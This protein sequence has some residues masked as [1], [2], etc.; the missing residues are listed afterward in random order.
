MP[1]TRARH[2]RQGEGVTFLV[3]TGSSAAGLGARAVTRR[4]D[5]RCGERDLRDK[6]RAAL[7]G[8]GRSSLTS[9]ERAGHGRPE[10]CW[11]RAAA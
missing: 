1:C 11:P 7:G 9:S 6:H 8:I 5:Q 2:R 10:T 4:A 3:I